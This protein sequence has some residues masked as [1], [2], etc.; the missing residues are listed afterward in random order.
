[1]QNILKIVFKNSNV[2]ESYGCLNL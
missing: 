1:L 2:K